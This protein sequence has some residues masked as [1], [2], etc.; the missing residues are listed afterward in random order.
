MTISIH[1]LRIPLCSRNEHFCPK[2]R[3][4]IGLL[5]FPSVLRVVYKTKDLAI[6]ILRNP[7]NKVL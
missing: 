7:V 1:R 4:I 5:D 2:L 6:R 3:I